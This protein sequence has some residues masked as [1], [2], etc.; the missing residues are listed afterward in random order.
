MTHPH[1]SPSA[2]PRWPILATLAS[3][4]LGA[5]LVLLAGGIGLQWPGAAADHTIATAAA[6]TATPI[7]GTEPGSAAV[8]QRAPPVR[9]STVRWIVPAPQTFALAQPAPAPKPR[10]A[11]RPAPAPRAEPVKTAEPAPA[12]PELVA[13]AAPLESL[14]LEP[15]T[16]AALPASEANAATQEVAA[17]QPVAHALPTPAPAPTSDV[18]ATETRD[19]AAPTVEEDTL[20]AAAATGKSRGTAATVK[21]PPAQIPASMR[22]QYDVVGN[23]KGIGYRAEGL[24]DWTVADGRYD[25]RLEMRVMLL[26][27]RSQTSTGRVGPQGLM[28]ERFADKTRSEKATHFDT[29]QQRIRFSNNAPEVPLQPGAQDRL[30]LFMQLA[31]LLQARPQ[32]YSTGQVVNMQVAGTGDAPVWRFEVGEESTL[33]V[34]AG[35]FRVRHLVRQPRKE[36]D[37]TVEMWLAPSLGH[38]PVRLRITQPNGDVADQKLRQMP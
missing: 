36:F 29:A 10:P 23:I 28:P 25:A 6:E 14:P 4:V 31:G 3:V 35:E 30:S 17:F 9:V 33:R 5:H 15:Q 13:V 21:L 24:L 20:M 16:E 8:A 12:T 38:M 27:S 22:L 19:E 34:P 18:T 37:S 2:S 1:R 7:A 32:A 26:G 11:P